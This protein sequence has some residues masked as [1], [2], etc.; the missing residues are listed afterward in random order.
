MHL[1]LGSERGLYD[2]YIVE[3]RLDVAD[4]EISKEHDIP[5]TRKRRGTGD[6]TVTYKPSGISRQYRDGVIPPPHVEFE[7]ELKAGLFKTR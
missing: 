3:V 4:F 6:V 1:I 7:R 5:G 2:H